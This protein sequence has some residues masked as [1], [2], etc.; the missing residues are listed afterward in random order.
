[1]YNREIIGLGLANFA[2]AM[3]NSYTTTGSFS[4]SAVNNNAGKKTHPMRREI[5]SK[6]SIRPHA[7]GA[8]T[9]MAQFICGWTVGFVLIWL[10]SYFSRVPTNILGSIIVVSV[11][12]LVE[13][14]QAIYLWKVNKLDFLVWLAAFLGVLFYSVEVGLAI[15]IGLALLLLV[16]HVAFPQVNVLGKL[17]GQPDVLR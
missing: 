11:A 3:S 13:Y 7:S 9:P 14:E 16:W 15:A 2:G 1:M 4:R 5:H 10:T 12:S 17:P 6:P 8:K